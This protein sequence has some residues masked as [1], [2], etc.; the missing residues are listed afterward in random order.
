MSAVAASGLLWPMLAHMGLT[1]GLYVWLTIVRTAAVR[2]GDLEYGAFVL[3]REEPREI[4]RITRNL[5]NQFEL[6][7]FFHVLA[8]VLIMLGRVTTIDVV[9]AWVFVAG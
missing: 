2:R 3:G 9:A 6:P 5:A 7:L 1:L 8:V 4:A